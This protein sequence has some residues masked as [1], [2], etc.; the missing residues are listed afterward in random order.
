MTPESILNKSRRLTY[1]NTNQYDNIVWIEDLNE[2]YQDIVTT[3]TQ[4]VNED[5]FYDIFTDD[6]VSGQNEYQ[7]KIPEATEVWMNKLK[8]LY[9]KYTADWDFK[10]AKNTSE[11]TMEMTPD[12]YETNQ[13]PET[14][15]F[16]IADNSVFIY[17]K[18]SINVTGGIRASV[19]TIP[20]DLLIDDTEDKIKLQRQYHKVLVYG[21]IPYIYT[22]RGMLNEA[23]LA[24]WIYEQL[25]NDLVMK[26]SD[27][28]LSPLETSLPDL[29]YYE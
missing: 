3:I 14:P 1:S 4:K 22:Q 24:N 18:P 9:I 10:R 8:E 7:F 23:Q 16:T 27:R 19:T 13:S 2:V 15:L 21:I 25:K 12:W 20:K 17:P 11:A 29:S 28:D 5:Y 6:L 26:L